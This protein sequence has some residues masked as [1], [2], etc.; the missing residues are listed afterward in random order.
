MPALEHFISFNDTEKAIREK[1][2]W[3]NE[4]VQRG[5]VFNLVEALEKY[6]EADS[7][8]L[9][10]SMCIFLRESLTFQ[11]IL[12][13]TFVGGEIG[14]RDLLHP[15]SKPFVT[16]SSY[17]YGSWRHFQLPDHDIY[18][19]MDK[20]GRNLV[21]ASRGEVIMI[22]FYHH[23]KFPGKVM[24][25]YD[26]HHPISFIEFSFHCLFQQIHCA[27]TLSSG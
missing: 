1:T 15:F 12:H 4:E 8:I 5:A 19:V 13:N 17:I 16:A 18:A 3:Y 7:L 2:V 14:A 24:H 20:K 23:K 26:I 6:C 21:P 10:K 27:W 9:L 25:R 22:M 11:E